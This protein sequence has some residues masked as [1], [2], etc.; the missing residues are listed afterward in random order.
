M[1]VRLQCPFQE[2]VAFDWQ[3]YRG[4]FPVRVN[5][6]VGFV[7]CGVS[8]IVIQQVFVTSQPF[9]DVDFTVVVHD[10]RRIQETRLQIVQ[11]LVGKARHHSVLMRDRIDRTTGSFRIQVAHVC[12][13]SDI[14]SVVCITSHTVVKIDVTEHHRWSLDA[15]WRTI[16]FISH[17]HRTPL[18]FE[19]QSSRITVVTID[20][21]PLD[22][23]RVDVVGSVI[24]QQTVL[25][26][27]ELCLHRTGQVTLTHAIAAHMDTLHGRSRQVFDVV[28]ND[29]RP[30]NGV[31]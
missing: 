3:P 23:V 24:R 20:H 13:H 12:T 17:Q 4:A 5:L 31:V 27:P 21:N 9:T 22:L 6:H 18:L 28:D 10:T 8:Q 16:A 1:E 2:V 15:V 30:L 26:E 25:N 7:V 19:M 29:F 14:P 11:Q